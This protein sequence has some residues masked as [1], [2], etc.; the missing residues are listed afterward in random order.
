[1]EYKYVEI[2]RTYKHTILIVLKSNYEKKSFSV[3]SA[4]FVLTRETSDL[5]EASFLGPLLGARQAGEVTTGQM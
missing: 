4:T 1:M 3:K 2:K 5:K